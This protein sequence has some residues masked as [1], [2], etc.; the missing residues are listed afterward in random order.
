MDIGTVWR[1]HRTTAVLEHS[2]TASVFPAEQISNALKL[3]EEKSEH[4][5]PPEINEQN[6]RTEEN[7]NLNYFQNLQNRIDSEV[8]FWKLEELKHWLLELMWK[9]VDG[10]LFE[11]SSRIWQLCYTIKNADIFGQL[12][13]EMQRRVMP[14]TESRKSTSSS[15][16]TTTRTKSASNPT[17]QFCVW[18]LIEKW[19]FKKRLRVCGQCGRCAREKEALQNAVVHET[20]T[21]I[22][23]QKRVDG[24]MHP[25]LNLSSSEWQDNRNKDIRSATIGAPNAAQSVICACS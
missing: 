6:Q 1:L 16:T 23:K 11:Q 20:S 10:Q 18:N 14:V 21:E 3:D 4:I 13:K 22:L 7:K 2:S 15:T 9:Y 12:L 25:H 5:D 17:F 24:W 19:C 8:Y